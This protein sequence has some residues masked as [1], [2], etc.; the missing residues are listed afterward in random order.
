MLK[1]DLSIFKFNSCKVSLE[2]KGVIMKNRFNTQTI[3]KTSAN[4][5]DTTLLLL[6]NL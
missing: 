2:I 5:K 4:T 1:C 6:L 3:I